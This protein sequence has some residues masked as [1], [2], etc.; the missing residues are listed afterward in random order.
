MSTETD[1]PTAPPTTTPSA[2]ER[3]RIVAATVA[4]GA[5]ALFLLA[6]IAITRGEDSGDE[7]QGASK[8]WGGA[9]VNASDYP[10]P[11]FTLTDTTGQPYDFAAQTQGKLTLLFFGYTHC[12]DVCPGQMT[13]LTA[14]LKTAGMPKPTVVF[15]T[16]DPARDTPERLRNWLDAYDASYV[17][18]TGTIDQIQQAELAAKVPPSTVL[19][20]ASGDYEVGHAAQVTA[21]T[22]DD[23]AHLVYPFGIRRQDWL[24]DLPRMMDEWGGGV[25]G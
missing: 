13:T 17:G 22:P 6:A 10:R 4:V 12:P 25:T 5:A 19:D 2:N 18:L 1:S 9:Q 20:G 11:Q 15:V 24:S 7:S 8:A 3:A 21:Y 23:Y 16:T 14:A